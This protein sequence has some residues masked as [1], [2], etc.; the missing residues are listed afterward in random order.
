MVLI[1]T[2]MRFL[3]YRSQYTIAAALLVPCVLALW[4]LLVPDRLSPLTY[5]L[6]TTIVLASAAVTLTAWQNGQG[7]G[8]MAQLIHETEV[9]RSEG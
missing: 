2:P 7:T 1:G 5:L 8:S 9:G 3:R 6:T 4:M